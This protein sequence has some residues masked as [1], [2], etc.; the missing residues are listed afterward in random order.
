MS[1]LLFL[2]DV[3]LDKVYK[4]EIKLDDFVFNLEHPIS[5]QG[6]PAQNKINLGSNKPNILETFGK[7]PVAVNLANNHIMD[8]GEEAFAKTIDYLNENNIGYF[9]AG[10][11]SN[12]FNN[13][14]ILLKD[15]KKIALFGYCCVS[16]D[17]VFGNEN[18]NGS[19]LLDEQLVVRD[20][21][22]VENE[23]DF[24]VVQLHWGEEE[25]KYPKRDDV[26]K[27]RMFIDAGADLII[28]HHAHVVQSVKKHNGKF[29]F[30][31]I[32]NFIFPDFNVPSNHDGEKFLKESSK[33]QWKSNRR[34]IL[35]KLNKDFKVSFETTM[36]KNGNVNYCKV[37]IPKWIPK[38]QKQYENYEKIRIKIRMIEIFFRNP[39]IPSLKQ[40]KLLLGKSH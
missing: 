27:S 21:K 20:I 9:G 37:R 5:T 1:D 31:G 7:F 15:K 19:A 16:T 33:V 18:Q 22:S 23:V 6:R 14:H 35:V 32:G 26:D 36:F 17:G 8:Y 13:P 11:T 28:G 10:N 24:I 34:S 12:N 4:V 29:I 38:T 3:F 2:G 30:Y 39:R 25:I 40:V